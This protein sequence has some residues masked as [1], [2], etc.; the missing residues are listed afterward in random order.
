[1][2]YKSPLKLSMSIQPCRGKLSL[3]EHLILSGFV[4]INNCK[5]NLIVQRKRSKFLPRNPQ[6]KMVI[7]RNFLPFTENLKAKMSWNFYKM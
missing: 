1:M 3:T 4:P 5:W 6:L 7:E 2:S